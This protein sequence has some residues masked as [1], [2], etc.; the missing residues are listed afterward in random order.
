MA[1][2]AGAATSAI[3]D[4]RVVDTG[5]G[6]LETC[7]LTPGPADS[8]IVLIG[9]ALTAD[10][11][12]LAGRRIGEITGRRAVIYRRRGYGA[13]SSAT[14]PGSVTSDAGDCVALLE[15]LGLPR[16]VLAGSSFSAAVALQAAADAP[17]RCEA[18]VVVE[19]P[20]LHGASE[21]EFRAA[22]ARLLRGNADEGE[23]A[24]MRRF[25]HEVMGDSWHEDLDRLLPGAAG[26][27][28]HD[29]PAFF[30]SD[31]PAL[32]EW[33]FGADDAAKVAAPVLIVNGASSAAWFA[34]ETQAIAPWF[35]ELEREVIPGAG[36]ALA[37]THPD[38]LA[39]AIMRFLTT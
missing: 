16:A 12:L 19:P 26:R 11:L 34:E 35:S 39:D 31:L 30:R 22:N 28:R 23:A 2:T 1:A 24:T 13:S 17:S 20:P 18:L 25:M 9:G 21:S 38:A 10:E 32:M 37:L 27:C 6:W 8:A 5:R 15:A 4:W 7:Q 29:A 3:D 14:V 36:H 33:Q